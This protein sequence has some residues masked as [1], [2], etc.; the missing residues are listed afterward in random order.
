M[1]ELTEHTASDR[2]LRLLTESE[3]R[4]T[5]LRHPPEGQTARAGDLRGPPRPAAH[6]R[7]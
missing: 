5:P 2:L 4:S 3:A 1:P 7:R 6:T